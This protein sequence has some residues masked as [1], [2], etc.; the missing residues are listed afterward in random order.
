[1]NRKKWPQQFAREHR[2]MLGLAREIEHL[3]ET[4]TDTSY[5]NVHICRVLIARTHAKTELVKAYI[6]HI[7]ENRASYWPRW[8]I[9]ALDDTA[10]WTTDIADKLHRASWCIRHD[11]WRDMELLTAECQHLA[12]RTITALTAGPQAN[13]ILEDGIQWITIEPANSNIPLLERIKLN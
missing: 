10:I 8:A 12:A 4:I 3:T 11:R 9:D 1:M 2:L 5:R 6:Q 13:P 7:Q